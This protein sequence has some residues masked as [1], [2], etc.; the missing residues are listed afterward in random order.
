MAPQTQAVQG[1][2]QAQLAEGARRVLAAPQVPVRGKLRDQAAATVVAQNK[3]TF[4]VA[5]D[6]GRATAQRLSND[7]TALHPGGRIKGIGGRFA[8]PGT[9]V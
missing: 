6:P 5:Q 2:E 4:T 1:F 8:G 7:R 9:L 3:P